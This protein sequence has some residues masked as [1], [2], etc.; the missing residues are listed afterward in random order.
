M[1]Y[2]HGQPLRGTRSLLR[3]GVFGVAETWRDGRLAEE[4]VDTN[5]DGVPDYRETYGT[6]VVRSWDWNG[7]GRDDSREYTAPDG[8]QVREV[9]TKLNGVFD[10]RVVSD[11]S[12]IVGITRGGEQLPVTRDALRG[13][14]WIGRAAP[15]EGRPDTAKPDGIQVIAGA[16]YL[17]F[18][19]ADVVY[20]EAMQE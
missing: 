12:R 16:P 20:A 5:G 8:R 14:T 13:V 19:F 1:W 4:T 11:G 3:D 18:R 2:A 9:S 15:A 7:D 17:V 10:L 6:P